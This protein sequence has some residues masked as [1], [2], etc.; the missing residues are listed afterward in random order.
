MND[1]YK[2]LGVAPTASDDEV[3]RAYRELA[4]KYHP[5]ALANN[6]LADLAEEKM[7]EINEAH[8]LIQKIRKEG[9]SA[10][11]GAYQSQSYSGQSSQT[12]PLHQQIRDAIVQGNIPLAEQ[13]LMQVPQK[14][15]E[16]YFLAGSIAY[17]KG[18][19]D[20]ASQNYLR[21]CQMAPHNM[22]YRQAYSQIQQK[23]QGTRGTISA[24]PCCCDCCQ[25]CLCMDCLCPCCGF[26]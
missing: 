7:K 20:E 6:P 17:R 1:P 19:I 23:T 5:D 3:K 16:W 21:A 11:Q 8:D 10:T 15:G 4:K 22:E 9:G 18:W 13:L 24:S 12:S 26:V 25:C 14:D 2:I